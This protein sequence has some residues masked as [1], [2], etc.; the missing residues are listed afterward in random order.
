MADLHNEAGTAR[1]H[2]LCRPDELWDIDIIEDID[3]LRIRPSQRIDTAM[4]RDDKRHAIGSKLLIHRILSL[5]HIPVGRP[6]KAVHRRTHQPAPAR[7]MCQR[8]R[9]FHSV[10]IQTYLQPNIMPLL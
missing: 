3:L 4:S 9:L 1:M 6:Q 7:K 2:E 10:H 8:N 5:R